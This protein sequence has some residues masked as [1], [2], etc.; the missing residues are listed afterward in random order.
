MLE[1][2][3]QSARISIELTN[4]LDDTRALLALGGGVSATATAAPGSSPAP[5]TEG[6]R[7]S[8]SKER[9]FN[10]VAPAVRRARGQQPSCEKRLAIVVRYFQRI[11][12]LD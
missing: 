7:S 6:S 8:L 11:S 5:S 12:S 10:R 4:A 3:D 2:G 9:P 1:F